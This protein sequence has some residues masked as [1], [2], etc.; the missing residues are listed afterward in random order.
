MMW[1]RRRAVTLAPMTRP[2]RSDLLLAL[3]LAALSLLQ[4]TVIYPIASTAAGVLVALA[5]TL[6]VAWRR[7]NPAVATVVSSLAWVIPTDG[8][9]FVGYVVAFVLYYSLAAHVGP[10]RTVLQ[11]A[12]L[13]VASSAIRGDVAGEYFGVLPAVVLPT[14]TGRVVRRLREQAE[15]LAELTVHLEH[16]RERAEQAAV[17]E[18]RGRIARE[19]HDVVAHGVSVIAIQADAAEAALDRD[20]EL[21][22]TPLRTIRGSAKQ[23][24]EEMRR[25]LDVLREDGDGG[26]LLPQPGLGQVRELVEHARGAGVEV[27]LAVD[28]EPRPLAPGLDLSAYRI[29]QEG[30]TNVRKHAA[31]APARVTVTWAPR[32]L[33]LEVSDA[34]P[35]GAP[36]KTQPTSSAGTGGGGHGLVGMRERVRLHGGELHAGPAPDGGFAVRARLPIG[37]RA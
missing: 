19:L 16:E 2:P 21:A 33:A 23:A 28:G 34:G 11:V 25:L 35:G 5:T 13:G 7:T 26:E 9:L 22:R 30:L 24:L 20:P 15:R 27:T 14:I 31:G 1:R 8:Y 36:V 17:V 29:V 3:G 18:E 12:A 37:D 4:V 10:S 32:E 6:P